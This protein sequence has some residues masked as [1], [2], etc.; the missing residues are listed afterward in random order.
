MV[1]PNLDDKEMMTRATVDAILRL[2]QKSEIP[3]VDSTGEAPEFKSNFDY[4]PRK[5]PAGK[6][7]RIRGT[8][9]QHRPV[10][11]DPSGKPLLATRGRE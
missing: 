2:I 7:I 8:F 3:T 5:K 1:R 10:P 9:C 4:P 11:T 6:G